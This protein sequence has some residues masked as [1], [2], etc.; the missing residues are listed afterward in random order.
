MIQRIQTIHLI[1][2]ILATILF[3]VTPYGYIGEFDLKAIDNLPLTIISSLAVL[4]FVFAI[5]KFK[6]RK[7]QKKL[8]WLGFIIV[9]VIILFLVYQ[10]FISPETLSFTPSY[11]VAFIFFI[12]VFL[13]LAMKGINNDEKIIKSMDRLR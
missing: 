12:P 5:S 4:T 1:L 8:I 9:D 6:N 11:G 2:A 10:Y 13:A 3:A 7:F